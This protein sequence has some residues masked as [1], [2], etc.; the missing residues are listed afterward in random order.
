V[1]V[2]KS[3]SIAEPEAGELGRFG[4]HLFPPESVLPLAE[5]LFAILNSRLF[6]LIPKQ[7]G[8]DDLIYTAM[9]LGV[10]IVFKSRLRVGQCG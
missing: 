6:L 3:H 4:Y 7:Q 1:V 2:Q 8:R 9:L 5:C 10:S